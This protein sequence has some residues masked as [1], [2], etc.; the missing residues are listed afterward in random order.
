[1]VSCRC[2]SKDRSSCCQFTVSEEPSVGWGC[3]G[4]PTTRAPFHAYIYNCISWWYFFGYITEAKALALQA[5]VCR[6]ATE[7]AP[8]PYVPCPM[9]D[10]TICV[11]PKRVR[12]LVEK[13]DVYSDG[14]TDSW[15][16]DVEDDTTPLGSYERCTAVGSEDGCPSHLYST[17]A[18]S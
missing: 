5:Y 13:R 2:R 6:W 14:A 17:A 16:S 12:G 18:E 7:T 10:C 4:V 3:R 8:T 15:A 9:H 1:M 11:R